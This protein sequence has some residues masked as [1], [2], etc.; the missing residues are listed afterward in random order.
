MDLRSLSSATA[1]DAVVMGTLLRAGL[2]LRVTVQLVEAPAGTLLWS[3]VMQVPVL[4]LFEVQDRVAH[5][6]V[7]ALSPCRFRARSAGCCNATFP[8]V[9]KPMA[10]TCAPTVSSTP[11]RTGTRRE[12]CTNEAVALDPQIR[13]GVGAARTLPADVGKVRW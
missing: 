1:V 8:R 5:A 11:R 2:E 4:D 7:E 13:A 3:Q 6:V 10:C 12:S 9:L